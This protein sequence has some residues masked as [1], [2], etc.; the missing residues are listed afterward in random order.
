MHDRI[1]VTR[2]V[3][4]DNNGRSERKLRREDEERGV[5]ADEKFCHEQER[6]RAD[7]ERILQE[8][9]KKQSIENARLRKLQVAAHAA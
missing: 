1:T 2:G 4:A 3:A 9:L 8:Q 7:E 6:L 5:A